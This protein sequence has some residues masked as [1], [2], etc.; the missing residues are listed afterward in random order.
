MRM[1]FSAAV[2][3]DMSV[4]P[5]YSV[6]EETDAGNRVRE[7]YLS[8]TG[9]LIGQ[10]SGNTQADIVTFRSQVAYVVGDKNSLGTADEALKAEG[11]HTEIVEKS[12]VIKGLQ[13]D[14]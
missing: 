5:P 13:Y 11:Y 10:G 3:E 14:Q 6:M 4:V 1:R 2:K 8:V 7:R 9:D 12:P